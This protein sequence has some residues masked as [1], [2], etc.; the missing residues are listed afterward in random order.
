MQFQVPQFIETE[1]RII[2]PLTIKQFL[3]IAA[4]GALCFAL[5]FFLEPVYWI[6]SAVFIMPV[7]ASL[8]FIQI[9]GRPLPSVALAA[10]GY[11]W[12]PRFYVWQRK[13]EGASAP[14]IS[15]P[16]PSIGAGAKS[17]LDSLMNQLNTSK[18]PIPQREKAVAPSVLD[19][20]KS[21]KERFEMMRKITGD[22]E[23]ARRVD[24]R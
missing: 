10:I 4:G 6:L 24:Y 7:S 15:A 16:R 9:N 11:Y 2:G 8:A 17:M 5:F 3:Y 18:N 1:D 21:S 19:R 12:K 23:M 14:K 20:V 13:E 22:K